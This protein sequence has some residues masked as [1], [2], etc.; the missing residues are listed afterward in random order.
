MVYTHAV[1]G[2]EVT[3]TSICAVITDYW[4]S[5]VYEANKSSK[6][7]NQNNWKAELIFFWSIVVFCPLFWSHFHTIKGDD[8]SNVSA[9]RNEAVR[10]CEPFNT[11]DKFSAAS[12]W[13]NYSSFRGCNNWCWPKKLYRLETDRMKYPLLCKAHCLPACH[14]EDSCRRSWHEPW[15]HLGDSFVPWALTMQCM[16]R[17]HLLALP[18]WH[19]DEQLF[20]RI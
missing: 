14:G 13:H 12:C 2:A 10:M 3:G 20:K 9:L 4:D 8:G 18:D 6:K 17:A 19:R 16:G 15:W 7:K 5:T 1:W 11:R